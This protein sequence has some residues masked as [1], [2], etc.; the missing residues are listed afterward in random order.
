MKKPIKHLFARL[1]VLG[2]RLHVDG[3]SFWLGFLPLAFAFLLHQP[4]FAV[5]AAI[6]VM[7]FWNLI[8]LARFIP[9]EWVAE[10][11][12]EPMAVRQLRGRVTDLE[13]QLLAQYSF[14]VTTALRNRGLAD[15]SWDFVSLSPLVLFL[16]GENVRIRLADGQNYGAAEVRFDKSGALSLSLIEN[17]EQEPEK[18][19]QVVLKAVE[20][21]PEG[22]AAEVLGEWMKSNMHD[23]E[24]LGFAQKA[25]G[26]RMFLLEKGRLPEISLWPKLADLLRAEGFA[27]AQATEDGIQLGIGRAA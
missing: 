18:A 1:R 2:I 16:S 12:P 24:D 19:P 10:K 27:S 6:A 7:V 8:C 9:K 3:G 26:K 11:K 22:S 15:A 25:Q 17:A 4:R 23:V 14:R 5:A 20:S 13:R 21:A